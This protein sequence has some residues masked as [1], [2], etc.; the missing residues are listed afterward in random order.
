MHDELEK[1]LVM[2]V[3]LKRRPK[4]QYGER[5]IFNL[6]TQ[7]DVKQKETTLAFGLTCVQNKQKINCNDLAIN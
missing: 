1:S 4:S 3:P 2:I 7:F 6:I 5:T